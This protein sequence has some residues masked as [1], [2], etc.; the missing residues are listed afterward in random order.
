MVGAIS[1]ARRRQHAGF[2][3]IE[4]LVVIAILGILAGVVVFATRGSG[5]KGKQAAVD[6]EARI[7]RTAQEVHC[8]RF[9]RY[10]SDFAELKEKKLLSTDPGYHS[11]TF[12]DQS[13]PCNGTSYSLEEPGSP[14]EAKCGQPEGWCPASEGLEARVWSQNNPLGMVQFGSGKVLAPVRRPEDQS[15]DG[16]GNHWQIYDPTTGT[17]GDGPAPAATDSK[18]GNVLVTLNGTSETCSMN[19]GKVLALMGSRWKLYEPSVGPTGAWTD[20]PGSHQFRQAGLDAKAVQISGTPAQCGANCGKVLIA[21]QFRV[22]ANTGIPGLPKN[23]TTPPVAELYDPKTNTIAAADFYANEG[24]LI[25][26]ISLTSLNNGQVLMVGRN[27]DEDYRTWARLFDPKDVAGDANGSFRDAAV[28]DFVVRGHQNPLAV[29][30]DGS[31]LAVGNT[32]TDGTDGAAGVYRPDDDGGGEW[33][34]EV[35]TCGT[36]TLKSIYGGCFIL[37]SLA[38]GRVLALGD[39]YDRGDSKDIYLFEPEARDSKNPHG[40]WRLT[41]KL[42][43][44]LSGWSAVLLTG[45]ACPGDRCNKVL[46]A[47][48]SPFHPF[49]GSAEIYTPPLL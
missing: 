8:A 32:G 10:A 37:T 35:G 48:G 18:N 23:T 41:G 29:L 24:D 14:E 46:A 38:D 17:W 42:T 6:A 49:P 27:V 28:P 30:P 12:N 9:G 33:S 1:S 20:V 19:C 43:D 47:G 7:L 25:S 26:D 11:M 40:K 36:G 5:D 4:L 21:G 34:S 22:G 31:V 2:T 3:L 16:L 15:V 44:P 39:A 45:A 13:G